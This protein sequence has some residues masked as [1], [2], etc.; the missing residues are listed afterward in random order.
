M[1]I[2][3]IKLGALLLLMPTLL[4]SQVQLRDSIIT[5]QHHSYQLNADNSMNNY[6]TASNVRQQVHFNAKVIENELIRLVVIPEY[7]ARVISFVYKP[8]GHENL[9]QSEC[10]SP[11]GM[12]DGNFYYDWLMVYGGIFPTFPEPEHG[13]AWLLPWEYDIVKSTADTVIIGMEYTDT[14][15]FTRAPGK[16]NNGITNI[17]CRIEIG[18][19][20]GSSLWDFNVSLKNNKSE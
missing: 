8:S 5:W 15:W 19:I 7:G 13:K 1:Y 14:T 12:N 18:V 6:S 11:Y 16:F 17:T 3:K 10:G 2:S 9:Y 4:F 20:K